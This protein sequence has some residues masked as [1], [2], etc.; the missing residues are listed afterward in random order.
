MSDGAAT[1]AVEETPQRPRSP[2][3]G[4]PG[5][6][7]PNKRPSSG[8]EREL[9]R[10]GVEAEI[11]QL[12]GERR[13]NRRLA[14]DPLEGELSNPPGAHGLGQGMQS[15]AERSV[16]ERSAPERSAPERSAGERSAPERQEAAAPALDIQR[17]Q[18]G[19]DDD[20]GPGHPGG[21]Y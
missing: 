12:L 7:S 14:V 16:S 17:R 5:E 10:T 15:L 20:V 11:E 2:R 3:H 18:I 13:G 6:R 9:A 4:D 19:D 21:A 8:A 1:C